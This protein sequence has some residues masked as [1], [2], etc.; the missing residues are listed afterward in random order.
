MPVS[1]DFDHIFPHCKE[2]ECIGK[3]AFVMDDGFTEI[4][5]WSSPGVPALFDDSIFSLSA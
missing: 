5:K 1:I 3:R 2:T 4:M